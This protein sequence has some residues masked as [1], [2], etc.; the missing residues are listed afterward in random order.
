MSPKIAHP[1]DAVYTQGWTGERGKEGLPPGRN[2]IDEKK[3]KKTTTR[4]KASSHGF[5]A[6]ETGGPVQP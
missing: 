4:G 3:K 1:G 6:M 5:V 2:I